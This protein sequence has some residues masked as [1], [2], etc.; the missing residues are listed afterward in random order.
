VL[1]VNCRPLRSE[2]LPQMPPSEWTFDTSA[3]DAAAIIDELAG[4]ILG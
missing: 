3:T 4:S 2:L 1:I